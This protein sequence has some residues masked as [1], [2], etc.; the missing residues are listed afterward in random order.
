MI[1]APVFDGDNDIVLQR[2]QHDC[3]GEALGIISFGCLRHYQ[4]ALLILGKSEP[5]LAEKISKVRNSFDHRVLQAAHDYLAGYWRWLHNRHEPF[6]EGLEPNA[7]EDWKKWLAHE[8]DDWASFAPELVRY[9]AN[10]LLEQNTP[11]G[12]EAEELLLA[13]LKERYHE[14]ITT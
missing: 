7:I 3:Y 8:V 5:L 9:T 10:A 14:M 6:L 4:S 1:I 11:K 13:A 2:E 12:Y